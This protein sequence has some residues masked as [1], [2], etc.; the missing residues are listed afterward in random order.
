LDATK[1]EAGQLHMQEEKFDFDE[2][3]SEITEELQRTTEKHTLIITGH[4]KKKLFADRERTGQVLTNLISNAIKYS[5]HT[6][7]IVIKTTSTAKAVTLCVQDYGVGIPKAKQKKLFDRFY[8]VSGPKENTFP[9]L[10]LGLYISSEIVKRLGGRIWVESSSGRGSIFCF[11]LP[12]KA[13]M[14]QLANDTSNN[15]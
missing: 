14:P 6:V 7:R 4:A 12:L 10:G 11:T 2:L 15:T 13:P 5:P 1:I 3:V 8:R 9:G